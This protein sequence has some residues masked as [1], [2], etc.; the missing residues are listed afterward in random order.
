MEAFIRNDQYN[1]WKYQVNKL[2]YNQATLIDNDVIKA[3][4]SLAIERITDQFVSLSTEQERLI[5]LTTQLNDEG[6]AQ[7]FLDQL[8]LLIIPFPA[9]NNTQITQLF[10]KA[11]L[12]RI[13][14][15][16]SERKFS[17][18]ISW[19]DTGQQ[20]RYIIAYVDHKHVGIE[21]RLHTRTVHGVCSICNHH[22]PTRQFTT[23]YKE[24]GDEG[25]YTSYSQ[26]VCSDTR[27]CNEN[28]RALDHLYTFISKMT[29][30]S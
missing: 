16:E 6:D 12:G 7:L 17:S 22:A 27:E 11:K 14:I 2:V 19:D 18:Y 1:E 3:V 15:Q 28:I 13:S 4:Q 29:K 25:N 10:P 9:I 8:A 23:S 5:T 24:R 20:K 26:Y 21:G 30:Q